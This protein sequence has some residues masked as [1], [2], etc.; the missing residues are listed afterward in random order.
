M[1]DTSQRRRILL[2]P[3]S[4]GD[5]PPPPPPSPRDLISA[6]PDHAIRDIFS[7]LPTEDVVRTSVLSK[8]WRYRWRTTTTNLVFN[9]VRPRHHRARSLDFRSIVDSVLSQHTSTSELKK[10]HVNGFFY[11]KADSPKLEEWLCFTEQRHVEDLCLELDT[12]LQ[13]MYILPHF[14]FCSSSLVRLQ[15]SRCCFSLGRTSINWPRLKVLLLSNVNLSDDIL[16]CILRGSPVLE[17]LELGRCLGLNNVVLDSTT[18]VKHLF[19]SI[20]NLFDLRRIRAPH[21][22]RMRVAGTCS[23]SEAAEHMSL[24]DISS[25]VEADLNFEILPRVHVPGDIRMACDLLKEFLEKLHGV[26]TITLGDWCLQILSLLEMKGVPPPSLTCQNLILHG[27]VSQWDLLGIAYNL[28]SSQCL[29][30][31]VLHLTGCPTLKFQVDEES[32]ERFNFDGEDFLCSRKGNFGCLARHLK[33]VEIIGFGALSFGLNHLL[34]LI[35]FILG[36]ALVLEKLI[37]KPELSTRL[38]QQPLQADVMLRLLELSNNVLSF[39][40]ASK[41]AKVIFYYPLE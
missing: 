24:E 14:L 10:F 13:A 5:R 25:L 32:K 19:L 22:L 40:R 21:L 23:C 26:P 36:H 17:S 11:D 8:R 29:E 35:K 18:S 3:E 37:I 39:R 12:S 15:V 31:L 20:S 16:T 6:L 34:P 1:A 9:R 33:R 38:A 7:Y 30:K 41:K 4:S 2:S 27:L 28:Q